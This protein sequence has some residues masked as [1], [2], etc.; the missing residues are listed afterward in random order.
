MQTTLRSPDRSCP[1]CVSALE[2]T[3]RGADGVRDA[4]V[5]FNTGRIEVAYDAEETTEEALVRLVE[6]AGYEAEV[7]AF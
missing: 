4:T 7:S 1:S 2:K 6:Q 3:L 5:H